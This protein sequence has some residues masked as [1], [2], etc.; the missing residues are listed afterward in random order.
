MALRH[1]LTPLSHS[2]V[3]TLTYPL[4]SYTHSHPLTHFSPLLPV[5]QD[6]KTVYLAGAFKAEFATL[7]GLWLLYISLRGWWRAR[8]QQRNGGQGLGAVGQGLG[9]VGQGLV[10]QQMPGMGGVIQSLCLLLAIGLAV[11]ALRLG[12]RG[13]DGGVR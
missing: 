9:A 4:L 1:P 5:G 10:Q 13:G 3:H 2:L 8:R 6:P 12:W 7:I 11:V